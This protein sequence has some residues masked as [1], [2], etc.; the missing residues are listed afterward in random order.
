MFCSLV[1]VSEIF[2]KKPSKCTLKERI[3]Y[4]F[5][6]CAEMNTVNSKPNKKKV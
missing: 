4:A 1:K 3:V 6:Y 2:S 5:L